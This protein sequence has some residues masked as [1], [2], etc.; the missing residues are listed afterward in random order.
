MLDVGGLLIVKEGRLGSVTVAILIKLEIPGH[1]AEE[2]SMM[3]QA[4]NAQL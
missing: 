4:C 2:P 1:K 3:M